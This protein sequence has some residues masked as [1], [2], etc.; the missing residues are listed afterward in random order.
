MYWRYENALK[1]LEGRLGRLLV[2]NGSIYAVRRELFES[3]PGPV[4]DDLAVPLVVA[5][6]GHRRLYERDAV[7]HERLPLSPTEEFRAKARIVAQGLE[8][9]IYYRRE[10]ARAGWLVFSQLLLHK[11]IRW[12]AMPLMAVMFLA[13]LAGSSAFLGAMLAGQV[14][15]YALALIG[16]VTS[17]PRWL[18]HVLVIPAYFCLVSAAAMRGDLGLPAPSP[19]RDLGQVREHACG[20]GPRRG[21]AAAVADRGRRALGTARAGESR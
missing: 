15:F 16:S 19:V 11:V 2:A 5:S 21:R 1:R 12:F 13:S 14:A 7:A 4:A 3:V 8:A 18:P 20:A 6:K 9:V 17:L 10:I